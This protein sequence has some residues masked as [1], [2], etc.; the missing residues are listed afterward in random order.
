MRTLAALATLLAA[1]TAFAQDV[2]HFPTIEKAIEAAKKDKKDILVDFTGSDWCGWC[3]RLNKEVFDTAEWKKEAAGKFVFV[4]LDFPQQKEI[5]ADQKA[6]NDKMQKKYGIQGFPSILVLDSDGHLYAR[7]GYQEGGPE[8]YLKHLADFAP[9]KDEIAKATKAASTG[10]D[11]DKLKALDSIL[12]KL[13]EWEVDAAYMDLKEKAVDAD[14][15][16]AGGQRL[17]YAKELALA[18]H[19]QGAAEKHATYLKVVKALDAGAAEAIETTVWCE[20][21]LFPILE[22][23]QWQEALDKLAPK[24]ELKGEA[25]QQAHYYAGY[26]DSRL[27]NSDKAKEHLK[28]ALDLAPKSDLGKR[29]EEILKQLK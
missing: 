26:C 16:N 2:A 25:G 17:K 8:A 20:K 9:R 27:G 28:K 14:P 11:A 19:S 13:A 3:I 22:K 1:P 21:E 4:E 15:K 23:A 18:Y 7:T 29:I 10:S 12:T 5:A 24:L 6:Y